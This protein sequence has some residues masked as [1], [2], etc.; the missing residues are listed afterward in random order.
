MLGVKTRS[1]YLPRSV[2]PSKEK[3]AINC[4]GFFNKVGTTMCT[5]E[6]KASS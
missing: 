6:R 2:F 5:E 4:V 3:A 1:N